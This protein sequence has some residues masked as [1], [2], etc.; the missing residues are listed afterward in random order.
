M[1]STIKFAQKNN[2]KSR[3]VKKKKWAYRAGK[4]T[5]DKIYR[6]EMKHTVTVEKGLIIDRSISRNYCET[7]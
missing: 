3:E 4:E 1:F 2:A 6:E 7:K 5:R